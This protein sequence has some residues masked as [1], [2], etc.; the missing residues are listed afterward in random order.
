MS[1][2][3]ASP[4]VH[5]SFLLCVA[6]LG[7]I[8][9]LA[10]DALAGQAAP[11]TSADLTAFQPREIGPAVTGG[12]VHDVTADPNNP[13]VIYVAS[14][15]GGLWKST[16]RGQTWANLTDDLPVSTF[17]DVALAPSDPRIVYAGTGEQNNRQ[18]TSWGAGV[19]RS[20]DGGTTWRH[21]GLDATRH[22]GK[23]EIHPTDPDVAFVAALGNLWADSPDRG[24]YR[25]R[26]GGATWDLV[27][28]IDDQTGAVDLVMDPSNPNVLYAATYQRQRRAWGFNGGG[29]GSGIHK[30][31]DAGESWTELTN[32]LP[33]GD[34]GRIGLALAASDPRI[35]NALVETADEATTGTYRTEDGGASWRR[36]NELD[37]RPMYYSE[38][39]IDPTEPDRVYT[40]ATSSHRSEDGGRNFTEIAVRP[41]YDVGVHADQHALWIDPNDPS[42]LY[43]GGDAGLHESYDY[44]TTWRKINNFVISQFYGIGVDMATPYRVYGGLQDNHSFVGPSETRRWAGIV[45]DDWQ[46]VGFGDG[47]FWATNPFDPDVAYGSSNDGT[48]FRLHARTGDMV[49]IEPQPPEGESYR[50]DWTSPIIASRHDAHTVYVAGNRL[51]TSRDRGSSWTRSDD[52]SRRIDRDTM[53]I[54]GVEGRNTTIS[55]NDGTGSFGEAVALAESPVDPRVLWVGFDDGNLQVTRDG[56]TT[57]TEVSGNVDGVADGTY[58]SRVV[59]SSRGAGVAYAAF[60]AHRSG[61]FAPY[62]FRTDDFGATWRALHSGLPSGSILGMAE[63]PDNPDVLFVGT[64]HHLFVSTDAGG[65][66]AKMP[67]LPTTAYDDITVHPREKDLVIATHGRGIWI[68]DDSRPIA[69]WTAQ[70]TSDPIHLFSVSDGT[71]FVYWKD[72][73]YRGNAEYA[74]TNPR[75]GVEVTYRLGA[76]SGPAT[77]TVRN[78]SGRVVRRLSVPGAQGTHRVNWDLRWSMSEETEAWVAHDNP[79]L[80][81][82][83]DVDGFFVSPGTYT[84]TLDA[85]GESRSTAVRVNGDPEVPTLTIDDYVDRESFLLEVRDLM[86]RLD[87]GV[88]GLAPASAGRMRQTLGGVVRAMNGGGVR[89]GTIHPPTRAQRDRVAAV[90]AAIGG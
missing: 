70:V 4:R 65:S 13:S 64:E 75:D 48:Y 86:S 47:M 3:E 66:W 40:M 28:S 39:F 57:F 83:T 71:I 88:T 60:D 23:V 19:Y 16:T 84:L 20:D 22:I 52:L 42:H 14:A 72:T 54:M 10:P 69:E 11:I 5:S 51:F 21:L 85:R 53:E 59:P 77:L 35:L 24:V 63:H 27:L 68:L 58:V 43:M 80:A 33:S 81:R 26:D 62:L 74:G 36:V 45:N 12:R 7:S 46:Q 61:D 17:G 73:S 79:L 55:R 32:G 50:F 25:T 44:G 87:A 9:A 67:N 41:T 89:P 34:K 78:A 29:P 2:H 15:S 18:S 38:I 30:T 76:G 82:P 31:T 90:R 49:D 6:L 8:T 56:G 1:V 37:V